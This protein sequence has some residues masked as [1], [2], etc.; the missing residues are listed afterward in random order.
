MKYVPYGNLL[1]VEQANAVF[2]AAVEKEKSVKKWLLFQSVMWGIGLLATC[3][4]DGGGSILLFLNSIT[5]FLG[6]IIT[7]MPSVVQFLLIIPNW[8]FVPPL[9]TLLT[10]SALKKQKRDCKRFLQANGIY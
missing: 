1:T 10:L 3:L 4:I 7:G 9:H 8:M 2:L 6:L 5:Y